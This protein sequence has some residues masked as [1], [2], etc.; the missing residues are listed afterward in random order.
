VS[1][2]VE[3]VLTPDEIGVP[4]G[5]SATVVQ[6]SSAFCM[7]CRATRAVVER[8]VATSDGVTAVDL[9]VADHLELG[10]RLGVTS[11]PTVLV[12]DAVG[13]VRVRAA[14]VPTLAQLRAAVAAVSSA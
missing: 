13:R 11:T 14:G 2:D 3:Q 1:P 9:D 6:I 7:P 4:L 10:E 8:A 5:G 12:L